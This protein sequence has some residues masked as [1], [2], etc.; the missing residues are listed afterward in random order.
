MV[1]GLRGLNS[2]PEIL[3]IIVRISYHERSTY[4]HFLN[5]QGIKIVKTSEGIKIVKQKFLVL[6]FCNMETWIGRLDYCN[7]LSINLLMRSHKMRYWPLSAIFAYT[8]VIPRKC[9]KSY[10]QVLL[11]AIFFGTMSMIRS[12]AICRIE[13]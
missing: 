10:F 8:G 7:A 1:S 13:H 4:Y 5:L 6:Y 12:A 9:T 11:L 3:G 2:S